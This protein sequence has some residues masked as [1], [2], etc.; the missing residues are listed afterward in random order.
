MGLVKYKPMDISVVKICDVHAKEWVHIGGAPPV[1]QKVE[2]VLHFLEMACNDD[3][4]VLIH[5]RNVPRDG[6][7]RV[8]FYC[9]VAHG[10]YF[11]ELCVFYYG[12]R[13]C[14]ACWPCCHK[15]SETSCIIGRGGR[16]G[17]S[18][19]RRIVSL[20]MP[21]EVGGGFIEVMARDMP[22]WMASGQVSRLGIDTSSLWSIKPVNNNLPFTSKHTSGTPVGVPYEVRCQTVSHLVG[23]RVGTLHVDS[24]APSTMCETSRIEQ[25]RGDPTWHRWHCHSCILDTR[26]K[27]YSFETNTMSVWHDRISLIGSGCGKVW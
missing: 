4:W 5:I 8:Q 16:G 14:M 26:K 19:S 10:Q 12:E 20:G 2:A 11:V 6:L 9:R 1:K 27:V 22:W 17:V 13:L 21:N 18:W 7:M 24:T 25:T 23:G 15:V 3:A